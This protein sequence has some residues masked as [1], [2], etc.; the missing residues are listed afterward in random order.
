M[1]FHFF[2]FYIKTPRC[3]IRT[4]ALVYMNRLR[5]R[6]AYTSWRVLS[7][8]VGLFGGIGGGIPEGPEGAADGPSENARRPAVSG[9]LPCA[10]VLPSR[11]VAKLCD[12][13]V[14][15]HVRLLS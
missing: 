13:H 5:F 11:L 12:R 7:L 14:D 15:L 8:G 9:V 10:R 3:I 2:Q 1:I 4:T 6:A